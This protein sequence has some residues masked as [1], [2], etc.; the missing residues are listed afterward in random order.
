MKPQIYSILTTIFFPLVRSSHISQTSRWT[1]GL[2]KFKLV[3]SSCQQAHLWWEKK[4]YFSQQQ[5]KG[6]AT[7]NEIIQ[8]HT[9]LNRRKQ[10]SNGVQNLCIRRIQN[11]FKVNKDHLMIVISSF[12]LI[13]C[14]ALALQGSIAHASSL[15]ND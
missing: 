5:Q 1:D 7:Q 14:Q 10:G 15:V 13:S 3:S 6:Y 12:T 4:L 8:R 9:Y 11:V 2:R